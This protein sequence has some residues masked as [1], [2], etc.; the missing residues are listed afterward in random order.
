MNKTNICKYY[1][2]LL[3]YKKLLFDGDISQQEYD[4]IETN[5]AKKYCIKIDSII[6]SNELINSS[7]RAIYVSAKKEVITNDCK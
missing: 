2:S 6:R 4:K 3:L 7:F 5:L 1:S